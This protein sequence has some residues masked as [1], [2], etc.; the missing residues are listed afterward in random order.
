MDRIDWTAIATFALAVVTVW[1]G[2]QAKTQVEETRI[3]R[4]QDLAERRRA[5]IRGAIAEAVENCRRWLSHEPRTTS[6]PRRIV[7]TALD[8][9]ALTA[10][11]GSLDLPSDLVAYF[12]WARGHA[13]NL[14]ARYANL[15][16]TVSEKVTIN[17]PDFSQLQGTWQQQLDILQSI[18][19]LLRAHATT[20]PALAVAATGYQFRYWLTAREAPPNARAQEYPMLRAHSGAP[21]FPSSSPAYASC[22]PEARD[23]EGAAIGAATQAALM[24]PAEELMARLTQRL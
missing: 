9:A 13:Q 20:D 15:A 1:L 11:L 8:S 12:V 22:S 2:W 5:A 3:A 7:P 18:A 14:A 16:G 6:D 21:E 23:T 19:C 17:D 4:A 24:R 10:L